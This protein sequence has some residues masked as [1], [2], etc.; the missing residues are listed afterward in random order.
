M[1]GRY[2]E[3]ISNY[4]GMYVKDADELIKAELK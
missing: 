3:P 1:D 4:K 2:T